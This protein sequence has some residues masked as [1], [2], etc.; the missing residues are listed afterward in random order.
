MN[1]VWL[2]F[3]AML[4]VPVNIS[5]Q[6]IDSEEETKLDTR[7]I[8]L[9]LSYSTI[10]GS[11]IYYLGKPTEMDHFKITGIYVYDDEDGSENSYFSLGM[12]YQRN[13][14][15]DLSNRAY[16]LIGVS[17][18]NNVATDTFFGDSRDDSFLNMGVG[19]GID[20]GSHDKGLII[21]AHLTYQFST[22]V[23]D[24]DRT[25]VGLGAGLGIGLNF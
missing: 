22:G 23:R 3:L 9:G 21:N 11:G 17:Y 2:F 20:F 1:R 24:S 18:D 16:T 7:N 15:R 13:V 25:R 6:D 12:E 14:F 8:Q 10:G 4:I 19:M 5:A